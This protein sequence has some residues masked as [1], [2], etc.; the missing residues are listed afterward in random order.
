M[1]K[2]FAALT[3]SLL[4]LPAFA[5]DA[6]EKSAPVTNTF[7]TTTLIE[8]V[9]TESVY[10]GGLEL[11]I[12]HRFSPIEN[13]HNLFGIYGAANT[14][15]ALSYGITDKISVGLGTT[16]DYKLQDIS[17]KWRLLE[18]KEDNS[19]PVTVAYYG[20]IVADL[21]TEDNFAPPTSEFKQ[22]HRLSYLTQIIVARKFGE[23]FSMQVAPTAVYYN[24]V[25]RLDDET[26]YKNFNLG[27]SAGARANLF[28]NHS[29]ILEYDQLLT[30]QD[31]DEQP[32][33]N[34]AFGWEIGTGTHSF[35]IFCSNYSSIIS[36]RNLVYNTN[37]K[38]LFGFNIHVRF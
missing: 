21:R 11:E 34:L 22:M 23:K 1:K 36:Q 15:I 20:N 17:W 5:Q 4:I 7:G 9:T 12:Q 37:G 6:Q 18:Q 33:P 16:K 31:L 28:G 25:T 13:Y 29:L 19:V 30:K 32:K 24:T 8:N 27:V 26:G 3:L 10:K 35:Q 38:Y 14:R 2:F